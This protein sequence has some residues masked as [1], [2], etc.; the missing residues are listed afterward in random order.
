[1][2]GVLLDQEDRHAALADLEPSRRRSAAPSAAQ[3]P[4]TARRAAAGAAGSSAP[5]AIASICCS[6][7]DSVP[8][9]W[10]S[11]SFRHREQRETRVR[12]RAAKCSTVAVKAPIRR[13]SDTV[14]ARRCAGPPAPARRPRHDLMR[15]QTRDVACR[16][17]R[18]RP[19]PPRR[20]PQIVSSASALARAVGA[21]QRDDLAFVDREC[22][23]PCSA[24]DPAV[25][26]VT[27][28]TRSRAVIGRPPPSARVDAALPARRDRRR[29]PAGRCCTSPGLPSAILTP[30]SSTT[31]RRKFASPPHVVLDQQDRDAEST[32]MASS[33]SIARRFRADSCRRSARRGRAAPGRCE[34]ARSRGAAARRR[35]VAGRIVGAR[36]EADEIEKALAFST[37]A[38]R[39][40]E[41]RAGQQP[42]AC[43]QDDLRW[44]CSATSRFS[45]TVMPGNRR[46]F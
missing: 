22:R 46:M 31:T 37:A 16:R 42:A 28:R 23:R 27:S 35:Q 38:L 21:D 4:S 34:R 2:E 15:R 10:P 40:A 43:S 44:L 14:S 24:C 33:K 20:M 1:M 9:S 12:D 17:S 36:G 25:V 13:F 19:R 41:S 45:S 6:P 32:R 3:A 26:G 39:R 29:S 8:P 18:P 7:P 11:R 30:W 5:G